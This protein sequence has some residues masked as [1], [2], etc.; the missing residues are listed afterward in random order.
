[1]LVYYSCG[2]IESQNTLFR[3]ISFR[4]SWVVSYGACGSRFAPVVV[5]NTNPVFNLEV[6]GSLVGRRVELGFSPSLN[7]LMLTHKHLIF[8]HLIQFMKLWIMRLTHFIEMFWWTCG[9]IYLVYLKGILEIWNWVAR[10][11]KHK[12]WGLFSYKMIYSFHWAFCSRFPH[13]QVFQKL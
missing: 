12:D 9:R 1:M 13:P 11:W 4:P 3:W 7:V 5:R 6:T 2:V 8:C 10:N